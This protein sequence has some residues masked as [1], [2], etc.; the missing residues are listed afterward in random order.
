MRLGL[1]SDIN[2]YPLSM[3]AS[4]N[5]LK[6]TQNTGKDVK[7]LQY[8]YIGGENIIWFRHYRK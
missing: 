3:V 7:E 1:Q 4:K 2:V 5:K 6:A 8:S